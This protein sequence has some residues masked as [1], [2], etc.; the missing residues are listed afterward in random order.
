[1]SLVDEEQI[2]VYW[3][4]GC[5]NCTRLKGYLQDRGVPFTAVNVQDDVDAF[6]KLEALGKLSIPWIRKGDA[7]V[8][9]VDLGGVDELIGL[10]ID[11]TARA[12]PINELVSRAADFLKI[13]GKVAMRIPEDRYN[14]LTPTLEKFKGAFFFNADGSPYVPHGT[15]K[16][17]VHHIAGH[18]EK[19]KRVALASD[20]VHEFGFELTLATGEN[21]SFGEPD[22]ATP[23]YRVVA[24]MELTAKDI[25]A[26]LAGGHAG[27]LRTTVETL[28]GEVSIHQFLQTM[29]CSLAQHTR[30]L[31]EVADR[32][33]VASTDGIGETELE[34]L[35]MPSGIWE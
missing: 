15:F 17:L 20:G 2:I 30:Q 21:I 16:S 4:P 11:P 32:C 12:L 33:G 35:L 8:Y 18:G 31:L 10:S 28:G 7:W 19:F 5:G 6:Q 14:D 9:G 29:T 27:D 1:M 34:G 22:I 25:R 13:A 3:I 26:W 23:M 24:A